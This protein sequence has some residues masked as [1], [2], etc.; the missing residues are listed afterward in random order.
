MGIVIGVDIGGTNIRVGAVEED[1]RLFAD[2]KMP[3]ESILCGEDPLRSFCTFMKQYVRRE[4]GDREVDALVVG[5]PAAL[6]RDRKTV[7]NAPNIR[8]FNGVNVQE[9]L[10]AEFSFPVFLEKDVTML[11]YH[12]LYHQQIPHEGVMIGCYIGTGLGNV[13]SIDGHLLAGSDGAACELGHIPLWDQRDLCTCGNEGCAE[14][15]VGGKYLVQLQKERFPDTPISDLFVCHGDTPEME[16]YIEHLSLPIATEIT[17][18]NPDRVLLGGGIVSMKG[19]PREKLEQYL[20]RHTRKPLP[21]DN[22]HLVYVEDTGKNGILGCALY[23]REALSEN[24][25]SLL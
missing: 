21:A 7:L 14:S 1:L 5:V 8:G 20:Y 16:R 2:R 12:D 17:I 10:Q 15:H 25:R 13:I 11:F 23:A 3:Q 4:A 6:S 19:F 22:L 9:K 18:L 24:R